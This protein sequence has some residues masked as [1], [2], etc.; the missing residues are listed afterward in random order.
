M[1]TD[2]P[3]KPHLASAALQN[4]HPLT[5]R[6]LG[7]RELAERAA[8]A[9][10]LVAAACSSSVGLAP[11]NSSWCRSPW[12]HG[13]C[14]VVERSV[15]SATP[16]RAKHSRGAWRDVDSAAACARLCQ[17]CG[18]CKY[19]SFSPLDLDCSW[20]ASCESLSSKSSWLQSDTRPARSLQRIL[21]PCIRPRCLS[22]TSC[23]RVASSPWARSRMQRPC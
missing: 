20:F 10:M 22:G 16:C 9:H 2:H 11:A 7:W 1:D 14:G 17:S 6:A 3:G 12:R 23:L 8:G 19:V 4:T 5:L 13:F 21:R 15:S 18:H